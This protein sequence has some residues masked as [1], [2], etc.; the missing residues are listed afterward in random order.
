MPACSS[1]FT[2]ENAFKEIYDKYCNRLFG[3]ILTLIH[4]QDAAEDITQELFMK[5][6]INRHTLNEVENT[7]RYVFTMAKNMTLNYIRKAKNN[8]CLMDQLKSH[9]ITETTH[10]E[11]ELVFSDYRQLVDNALEQLS[12]QRRL[13][14]RLSRYQGLK[15]EEIARQLHLSRNTVKNHLA[16]ALHFIRAY[17]IE[18]G[19]TLLLLGWLFVR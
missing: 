6:W 8:A 13:V 9:M 1:E 10:V 18:H 11:D 3:F 4:S 19:V 2:G 7:E 17:L 5:I 14:F 15:L 16:A 12:P